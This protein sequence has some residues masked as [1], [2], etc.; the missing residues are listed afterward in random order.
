MDLKARLL[1][2]MSVCDKTVA[3]DLHDIIASAE[4][5]C[6]NCHSKGTI[7]TVMRNYS[8]K[9]TGEDIDF[10]EPILYYCSKCKHEYQ[11]IKT[12]QA[13][14]KKLGL[15]IVETRDT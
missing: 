8:I 7:V 5:V 10:S 2:Y 15:I 12:D 6:K 1:N 11:V 14:F 3:N 9:E 4:R 13:M